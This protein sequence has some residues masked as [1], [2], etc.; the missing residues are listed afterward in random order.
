MPYT[1]N[2][3]LETGLGKTRRMVVASDD[4]ETVKGHEL[5]Q[6]DAGNFLKEVVEVGAEERGKWR[7]VG[8]FAMPNN[9]KLTVK[10]GG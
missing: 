2:T 9:G 4:G 7:P 1:A 10:A 3:I 6:T 5:L 8:R